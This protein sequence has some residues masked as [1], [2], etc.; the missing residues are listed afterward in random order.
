MKHDIARMAVL[1]SLALLLAGCP[2]PGTSPM[3]LG[4]WV[5]VFS[6]LPFQ[7][8][9]GLTLHAD[10]TATP[11]QSYVGLGSL[12]GTWHWAKEGVLVW[13]DQSW[14]G[15]FIQLSGTLQ[16]TTT[17]EGVITDLGRDEVIGEWA[18]VHAP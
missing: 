15:K 5:F 3:V 2:G 7:H 6:H 13:F 1:F 10:G 14:D 16:S 18:A 11:F 8:S 17:A 4:D 12:P 9:Y